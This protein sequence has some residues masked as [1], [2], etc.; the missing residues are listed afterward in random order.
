[1]NMKKVTLV[2]FAVLM[3]LSVNALADW[4]EYPIKAINGSICFPSDCYVFYEGMPESDV[5]QKVFGKTTKEVVKYLNSQGAL[6]YVLFDDFETEA[7]VTYSEINPPINFNDCSL[8]ELKGV[9]QAI[10]DQYKSMGAD[11]IN[12][13]PYES[14][15]NKFAQ[16]TLKV[17]V[18][19]EV[20]YRSVN[21]SSK[22][23]KLAQIIFTSVNNSIT[24]KEQ[25]LFKQICGTINFK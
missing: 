23:K 1:M 8:V 11:I 2:L 19:S 6:L 9:G 12:C 16:I 10:S 14:N 4:T 7:T 17:S 3:A 13:T 20:N 18:G 25:E 22:G 21:M 15:G 5:A 24:K